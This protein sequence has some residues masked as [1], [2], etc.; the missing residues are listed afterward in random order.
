MLTHL[1]DNVKSPGIDELGRAKKLQSTP[2][3]IKSSSAFMPLIVGQNHLK[4]K[5]INEM[6]FNQ[7]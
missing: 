2:L 6:I 1:T 7:L 4:Y 5:F 3:S